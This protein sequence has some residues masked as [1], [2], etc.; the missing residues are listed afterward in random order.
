MN[1][2]AKEVVEIRQVV[3]VAALLVLVMGGAWIGIESWN[4]HSGQQP[5]QHYVLMHVYMMTMVLKFFLIACAAALLS[6]EH[7]R[8]TAPFERGLPIKRIQQWL[9]KTVVVGGAILLLELLVFFSAGLGGALLNDPATCR[10]LFAIGLTCIGQ[11]A[12][13]LG[14]A[15]LAVQLIDSPIMAVMMTFFLDLFFWNIFP[16]TITGGPD[17]QGI[18]W[19]FVALTVVVGGILWL[20][21]LRLDT[22]QPHGRCRTLRWGIL[23]GLWA[24]PATYIWVI[25]S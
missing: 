20:A 3:A 19:L 7:D 2:Y 16:V 6:H 14:L 10:E 15:F 1:R 18:P 5:E 17:S 4:R 12:G 13:T 25:I 22:S 9:M 11:L 8:G 23:A 24:V 21:G